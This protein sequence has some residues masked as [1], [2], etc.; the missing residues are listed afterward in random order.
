MVQVNCCV[1]MPYKH[2]LSQNRYPAGEEICE[3]MKMMQLSFSINIITNTEH[4][5]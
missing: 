2:R 1:A 5:W 4:T 3:K